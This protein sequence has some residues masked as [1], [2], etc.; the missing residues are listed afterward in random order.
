MEHAGIGATHVNH[1]LTAMNVPPIGEKTLRAREK[2][3]R[4]VVEAVAKASCKEAAK[5]EVQRTDP[6]SPGISMS[7]DM[8]WQKRGRAMNSLTGV[9]HSVGVKT[10]KVISYATR[11]KR[12]ATCYHAEEK[13]ESP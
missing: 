5:E 12:C 11:S 2:E 3:I 7:Y 9:G 4:P 10:G 13:N 8:G 1:L 6:Q